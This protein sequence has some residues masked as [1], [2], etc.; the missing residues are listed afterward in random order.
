M[1]NTT[2]A[3]CHDSMGAFISARQGAL[4]L[5]DANMAKALCYGN[6]RV[7]A[8]IKAGT[9]SLPVNK[10]AALAKVLQ[11]DG[12][13]LLRLVLNEMA[14][15]LWSV[16][17]DIAAPVGALHPTEI[18]LLRHLRAVCKGREARPIVFDGKEVVA[19]VSVK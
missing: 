13:E 15:E 14:P 10:V 18:N 17:A 12:F 3:G 1:T 8:M 6:E 9:M 2:H 19:L 16:I 7:I 5:T 11:M 4:G